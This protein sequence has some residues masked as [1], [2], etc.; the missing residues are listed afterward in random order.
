MRLRFTKGRGFTLLELLVVIAIIALLAAMLLPVLSKVRQYT[1]KAKARELMHQ[2][3]MSFKQYLIDYRKFPNLKVT[4]LN[5]SVLDVVRGVTFNS[6]GNKY[7]D[8]KTNEIAKGTIPDPWNGTYMM[9]IDNGEDPDITGYDK[10]VIAGPYGPL[11]EQVVL[12][13]KGA[14]GS[15][16]SVGEQ[17]DDVRSWDK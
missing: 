8:V 14:D 1:K 10:T 5:R 12:W 11:E 16:M 2:V 7:M 6:L 13:T 3:E 15:D 17:Q 9:R 4:E